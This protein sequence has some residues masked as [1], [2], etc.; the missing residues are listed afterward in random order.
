MLRRFVGAMVLLL[1]T[2]G[3]VCCVAGIIGTWTFCQSTP[4]RVEK[5]A[6]GL[7][8]AL[9]RASAA[10]QNAQRAVT[11]ARAEVATVGK[12]SPDRAD[13]AK[14]RRG[15]RALRTLLQQRVG[16]NIDDVAGRLATMSDA[17]V[18]VAALL[19][20]FQELPLSRVGRLQPDQAEQWT[21]Q[22]QQLSATLRQLEAAVGEG[23]QEP[24]GQEVT[25]ATSQV[26][27]VL[28]QCQATVNDWQSSLDGAREDLSRIKAL[29]LRWLWPAAILVILLTA[30]VALGQISLFAH[31]LQWCRRA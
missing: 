6:A 9:Q 17:A 2:V 31:G 5:I 22:A 21:N 26:D 20:G 14:N 27:H 23:D 7:D 8:A 28:Q 19:Q 16:P 18:A 1:A 24:S 30:W 25:A 12:E 11:K 10:T 4:E 13:G 15:S 29:V 3:T